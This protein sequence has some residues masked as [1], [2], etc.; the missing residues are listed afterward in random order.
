[1]DAQKII[2]I[3]VQN[4]YTKESLIRRL[5]IFRILLEKRFFRFSQNTDMNLKDL[6]IDMDDRNAVANWLEK[7]SYMFDQRNIYTLLK[8]ISKD[9]EKLPNIIFYIACIIEDPQYL[10]KISAWV[11]TNIAPDAFLELKVDPHKVGGL[12]FVQEGVL[13]DYSIEYFMKQKRKDILDLIG[14]Y[15][16]NQ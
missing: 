12:A 15:A 9:I 11:R 10:Q 8:K 1:M 2:A 5:R 14:S 7:T 4:T 6:N 3:I 13:K 16:T